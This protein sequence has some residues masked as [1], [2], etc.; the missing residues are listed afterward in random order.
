M[1]SMGY[2]NIMQHLIKRSIRKWAVLAG[3]CL[4]IYFAG[5][6]LGTRQ[7]NQTPLNSVT[8]EAGETDGRGTD[9]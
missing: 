7:K 3:L 4:L 6:V 8:I 1:M 2:P 5:W 9:H